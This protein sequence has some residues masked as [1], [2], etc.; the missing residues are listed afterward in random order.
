MMK[1]PNKNDPQVQARYQAEMKNL[2]TVH[3]V[4]PIRSMLMPMFQIPIFISVFM[5][6]RKMGETFEGF[7]AGGDF[8]FVNLAASDPTYIFPIYNAL[9]FLTMLEIGTLVYFVFVE[10]D[11]TCFDV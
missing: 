10:S 6:L 2:F 9:T 4:N 11:F 8:W 7:A 3:N 5:A 1:D